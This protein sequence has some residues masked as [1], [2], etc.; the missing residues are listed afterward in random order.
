MPIS[1]YEVDNKIAGWEAQLRERKAG[2][3]LLVELGLRRADCEEIGECIHAIVKAK[4]QARAIRWLH[5]Y[6]PL[7]LAAFLAAE[8]SYFYRAGD[9]WSDVSHR[10]GIAHQTCVI[11]LGPAFESILKHFEL[12]AFKQLDFEDATRYVSKL[13]AH[14][15]IPDYSLTDFFE[16]L[17]VRALLKPEW[18]GMS[19]RELIEEWRALPGTF[20]FIDKPVRRFL[21]Y[22]GRV[23]EDFLNRCKQMAERTLDE[24]A[25]PSA[26]ELRLPTRVVE[27][28][29]RWFD[30][31]TRREGQ[32]ATHRQQARAIYRKPIITFEPW[33][34][35]IRVELPPQTLKQSTPLAVQ[36]AVTTGSASRTI[37]VPLRAQGDELHS[38]TKTF[39]LDRPAQTYEF[40]FAIENETVRTWRFTGIS[41][42]Q[43]LLAFEPNSG[44]IITWREALPARELWLVVPHGYRLQ[45]LRHNEEQSESVSV[46]AEFPSLGH[47]WEAYQG[48]HID[49]TH[50]NWLVIT[51]PNNNVL[52][53]P[54]Q[55]LE[56]AIPQPD[57]IG[58]CEFLAMPASPVPMRVFTGTPP[59][60]LIP[61]ADG[62][63][64]DDVLN[65]TVL[66]I[67][68]TNRQLLRQLKFET[69]PDRRALIFALDQ[70]DCLGVN[71]LGD[72]EL[73]LVGALG[74]TA[75][76]LLRLLP[77]IRLAGHDT[78]HLPDAQGR[79]SLARISLYAPQHVWAE[80]AEQTGITLTRVRMLENTCEVEYRIEASCE[81]NQI[82][83]A[84]IDHQTRLKFVI[85][86]RH[87]RWAVIGLTDDQS[88]IEWQTQAFSLGRDN[89]TAARD[90]LLIVDAP[91][92]PDEH[93]EA[94]CVLYASGRRALQVAHTRTSSAQAKY[95]QF[96]LREFFDTLRQSGEADL[97]LILEGSVSVPQ[98][99][100]R[101]IETP[102][103]R[104]TQQYIVKEVEVL[105]ARDGDTRTVMLAWQQPYE[106]RHRVIRFWPLYRP[107]VTPIEKSLPDSSHNEFIFDTTDA[108]LPPGAYRLEFAVR[109]PWSSID[110]LPASPFAAESNAIDILIGDSSE[111][112]HYLESLPQGPLR[113]LESVLALDGGGDLTSITHGFAPEHA[114]ALLEALV[115]FTSQ[116]MRSLA[117]IAEADLQTLGNTLL[118]QPTA[119]LQALAARAA[120]DDVN[121]VRQLLFELDVIGKSIDWA[122]MADGLT[123]TERERIWALLPPL[124]LSLDAR[125]LQRGDERAILR[126]LRYLGRQGDALLHAGESLDDSVFGTKIDAWLISRDLEQLR[127]FCDAYRVLPQSLMDID[128]WAVANMEWVEWMKSD[129]EHEQ[130]LATFL[131]RALPVARDTIAQLS[132]AMASASTIAAKLSVRQS[133]DGPNLLCNVPFVSGAIALALRLHARSN[134]TQQLTEQPATFWRQLAKE[135]YAIAPSLLTRDLCMVELALLVSELCHTDQSA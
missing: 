21:L 110:S 118:T 84:I 132:D 51:T 107:W 79:S 72:F 56:S 89:L 130:Q 122:Q 3:S 129:A 59:S 74:Q 4:G 105:S 102:L 25:V 134:E 104:L 16:R 120:R 133:D 125:W 67:N 50:F 47:G 34:G 86:I 6:C 113:Q 30:A 95:L 13:L 64:L 75:A 98:Q 108:E 37:K 87:V 7:T 31:W 54:L 38:D 1:L 82:T 52:K 99:Q 39:F 76:F 42:D 8:G 114:P 73:T 117:R 96:A 97:R 119:F 5:D 123:D 128:A 83:V 35:F 58:G 92:N 77:R 60:L 49:L 55:Q 48:S 65:H 41:P 23:A 121:I 12:P 126:A 94:H 29:A 33:D 27:S 53:I 66:I 135:M 127:M 10:T 11:K 57:L 43:P 70:P 80:S 112:R 103:I 85:P 100:T 124:G 17:L 19:T 115:A 69:S 111:F 93:I 78:L 71:P 14:G 18:V 2:I 46:C 61:L 62:Q 28:F 68:Q 63:Q 24:R 36:W 9:Y 44:R 45:A 81:V 131:R 15:G 116:S 101:I 90:P 20:V 26:E 91:I 32:Q 22:G 106:I 40:S 88:A 109:D